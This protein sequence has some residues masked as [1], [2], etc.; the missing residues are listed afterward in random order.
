MV[1]KSVL[2]ALCLILWAPLA[3][4][5]QSPDIGSGLSIVPAITEKVVSA[6]QLTLLPITVTNITD[7]AQAVNV[8][9]ASFAPLDPVIDDKTR[10]RFD[11]SSWLAT[12]TPKML[13]GPRES[14]NLEIRIT[15]P[16][17]AGAG[18]HYATAVFRVLAEGELPD[19][20]STAVRPEIKAL[21]L[22]T[23]PGD[24]NELAEAE[25]I[26]PAWFS[27]NR[28]RTVALELLNR[29]NV[30]LLPT[31][32]VQIKNLSGQ[33]VKELSLPAK[34]VVPGTATRL[35][36][37]WAGAGPGIY[38]LNYSVT[39][40]SPQRQLSY[41]SPPVLVLPAIWLQ[42]LVLAAVAIIIRGVLPPIMRRL[43]PK[44]RRFASDITGEPNI[45][46]ARE[47]L[48]VA[49]RQSKLKDHSRRR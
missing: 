23:V 9:F 33:V 25:Y 32:K 3:S 20:S 10:S 19:S 17:D 21:L 37:L 16:G 36:S 44:K 2:L 35:D 8:S 28:Q 15:P 45:H 47:G 11:A 18:G 43:M 24:I 46:I 14:K 6:G 12:D 42:I 39:Y 40:G 26:Y 48:E 5:A 34:L 29:G 31:A 1:L 7:R 49:E 30:H 41:L 27:Q 4:V 38:R 22:L 13:L